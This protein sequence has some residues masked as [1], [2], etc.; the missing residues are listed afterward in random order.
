MAVFIRAKYDGSIHKS[1]VSEDAPSPSLG[2]VRTGRWA[3]AL[4]AYAILPP[5]LI[6][7]TASMDAKHHER[8]RK[9]EDLC[10]RLRLQCLYDQSIKV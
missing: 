5:S 2:A 8:R 4:I 6:S 3:W 10:T 7:H 9:K 1:Q